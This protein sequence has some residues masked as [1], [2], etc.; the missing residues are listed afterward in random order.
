[1][2]FKPRFLVGEPLMVCSNCL[3]L[4]VDGVPKAKTTDDC[5][6]VCVA[7]VEPFA[8][9]KLICRFCKVDDNF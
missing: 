8:F 2:L 1:M 6:V 5:T 3:D 7:T 4:A 9:V